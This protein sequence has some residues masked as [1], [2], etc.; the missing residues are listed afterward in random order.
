[1]SPGSSG[2]SGSQA[3][4]WPGAATRSCDSLN[5][6]P[7]N[8]VKTSYNQLITYRIYYCKTREVKKGVVSIIDC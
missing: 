1:M 4:G 7:Q 2:P 6:F 5:I 3:R 8:K